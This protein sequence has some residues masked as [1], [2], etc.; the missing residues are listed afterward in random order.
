MRLIFA[1][2]PEFAARS[3]A[4]LARAGHE[5]VLALTRPD[6]PAGR[7]L[8]PQPSAVKRL[9]LELGI[10]VETPATLKPPGVREGLAR[11]SP[12]ALVVAAYG[13]IIPAE[14]L[15]VPRLGGLNV[16][17][18]LLPRWRGAAPIQRAILAGD[19]ETGITIMQMDAGLDTGDVLL[20]AP[21]LILD[22]DTAGSL[23][24][25][26]AD[27]GA[28]LLVTAL[29]RAGAGGLARHPQDSATATY[30]AKIAKTEARLD[31]R[32][33]A[34]AV[35]RRVRAFNPAPGATTQWRGEAVKIWGARP[36]APAIPRAGGTAADDHIV[37]QTQRH[38]TR[39]DPTLSGR[40]PFASIPPGRILS[41]GRPGLTVACGD[42]ALELLELQRPGGKRLPAA[43]FVAS[44]GLA[45]GESFA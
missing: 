18:S 6:R 39:P 42:A 11:F 25:R 32:E 16:H 12:D 2:T 34:A 36:A 7:G 26:L 30:A 41:A 15:A 44:T 24:D 17:A 14:V 40:T 23:H 27:L 35:W 29:E 13:L 5:V 33:P 19:A 8:R 37:D 10:P 1:G 4:A 31:W 22:A 45:A 43:A 20:Q 38:Q 28:G 3:L 9:A 21:T